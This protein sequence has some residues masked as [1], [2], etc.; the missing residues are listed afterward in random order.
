MSWETA[1]S[2]GSQL[3]GGWLGRES[4]EDQQN[5]N[6][7]NQREFAQHGI[8]W[9][10]ADAK[11]AGLHPVYALGGAGAAYSPQPII[12]DPVAE[13]IS[14]M[15]QQMMPRGYG[16]ATSARG[17]GAGAEAKPV[18]AVDAFAYE[19]Q[20]IPSTARNDTAGTAGPD[21]ALWTGYDM[22]GGVK[23]DMPSKNASEPLETLGE[24]ALAAGMTIQ[25]NIDKYGTDWLTRF[26]E[27]VWPLS[28]LLGMAE[29]LN[30][31]GEEIGQR[32]FA[33]REMAKALKS[34]G[35][36]GPAG[37]QVRAGRIKTA[38]QVRAAAVEFAR[39]YG[40]TLKAG[41]RINV[42]SRGF[43]NYEHR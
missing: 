11:A 27:R 39:K 35:V 19:A 42:P 21:Q 22:G 18:P 36:P 34:D 13:A 29:S 2:I 38:E 8:R 10:V 40:V 4:V 24:S 15:G 31:T 33:M 32:M 17:V 28:A 7:A 16:T 43:Y 1:L 12:V 6:L 5:A 26:A 14:R 37:G 41:D 9:R 30:L 25:R 20:Q 23:V 3:L